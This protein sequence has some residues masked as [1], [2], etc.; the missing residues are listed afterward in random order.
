MKNL[1][2]RNVSGIKFCS[3]LLVMFF[4]FSCSKEESPLTIA[5]EPSDATLKSKEV[6]DG[7]IYLA[8]TSH[9]DIYAVKEKIVLSDGDVDPLFSTASLE[10]Y[11]QNLRLETKEYFGPVDPDNLYREVTFIGKITPSGVVMFSWPETWK[12]FGVEIGSDEYNVL[13]QVKLHL[14]C[15]NLYGPGIN[16]E[17]LN[18]KG[19]FDGTNFYASTHFIGKQE[20]PGLDGPL[21]F[22]FSFNLTKVD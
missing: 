3:F 16:K 10:I 7:T 12:E 8:G 14:S 15:S 6:V 17:T 9:F 21:Q 13:D 4:V 2:I 19:H 5:D 18:Y 20:D 1:F 22:E 11:G